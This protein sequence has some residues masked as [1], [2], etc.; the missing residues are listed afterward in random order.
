MCVWFCLIDTWWK[1]GHVD[2]NLCQWQAAMFRTGGKDCST[3]TFSTR[4]LTH[5]FWWKSQ[6]AVE[7]KWNGLISSTVYSSVGWSFLCWFTK[8][9][10]VSWS[11]Y[12]VVLLRT[13][14]VHR[15]KARKYK[16]YS[17]SSHLIQNSRSGL[18]VLLSKMMT[19]LSVWSH[20]NNNND[21]RQKQN[22]SMELCKLNCINNML[23]FYNFYC[24]L[25]YTN[26]QVCWAAFKPVPYYRDSVH[27][28]G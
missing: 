20:S 16:S 10:N 13:D 14:P 27:C 17:V 9:N 18:E 22:Y 5:A 26:I 11:P 2:W 19:S 6:S 7:N 1:S 4:V 12:A 28:V 23:I 25:L 8:R 24:W 15:Q 3:G 21:D